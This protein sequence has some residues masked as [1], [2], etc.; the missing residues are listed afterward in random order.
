MIKEAIIKLS[1][2]QDIGY[3]MAKEVMNEIMSGKASD[4]QK[5]AYLATLSMKGETIGEITA[6]AEE[7]RNHCIKLLH[8]KDV[9][10]IVGTGGDGSNSFNIS[11]TSSIVIA[12]GDV[13][14]AKHGNRAAS[15]KCGA[16]DVLEALGVN[17]TIPPEKSTELLNKI[18]ICFLFA[19][20]YHIAMK[21][22]APVRKELGIRTVFNVLG[23]LINPAGA[24]IELMGVYD[25]ELIEP[26]ARVLDNLGVKRALVVYGEDKLDE[27]SMSAVTKVCEIKDGK[28]FSYK[29]CPEDF[30]FKRCNKEEL[31]GGSP[32][33]NAEITLS[34]L[35]GV[36]GPKRNAVVLNAG[37][38]LY[39]GGKAD[40]IKE[41]VR[42]AEEIIDSGKAKK[43]LE[44]F[45]KFSNE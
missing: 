24:N 16:A 23:P 19:Q 40:S 37:A 44:D 30:G 41:G 42:L 4:I 25:E 36:R 22:V 45:I 43:K 28:F 21:Y 31:V 38:A 1:N 10:E 32:D 6:S 5:S 26:L 34:I 18:G 29:I 9:L 7:M 8:D 2:K 12:A 35:N 14:V 15:S 3:N 11:T 39:L 20:N 33:E 13:P 17:I 27:I